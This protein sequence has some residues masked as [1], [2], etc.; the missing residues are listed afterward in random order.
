MD[1]RRNDEQDL[2][3]LGWRRRIAP[4]SLG[5]EE[6]VRRA[7][8]QAAD[9]GVAVTAKR[10]WAVRQTVASRRWPSGGDYGFSAVRAT[11]QERR[12]DDVVDVVRELPGVAGPGLASNNPPSLSASSFIAGLLAPHICRH[13]RAS[14]VISSSDSP[15]ASLFTCSYS[16][17]STFLSPM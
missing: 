1:E 12:V 8:G 13:S 15:L 7:W 16:I 4:A 10:R 2:E 6:A 3:R 11:S 5:K 9:G 14:R 17:S